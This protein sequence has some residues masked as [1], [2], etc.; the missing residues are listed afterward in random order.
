MKKLISGIV[1]VA[2]ALSLA[3]CEKEV[4]SLSGK[5]MGTTYHVK[6]L[7]EGSMKATSEKTHEEIEAILKDVNAKMSTYK[8]DSELSRFNQ[9]TQVNTPIEISADFDGRSDS[10]K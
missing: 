9:N 2:M 8:K 10:F 3:A 6:Y 1:A 5:T 4:I 7:D